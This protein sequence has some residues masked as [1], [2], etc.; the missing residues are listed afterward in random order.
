VQ[1]LCHESIC[2]AV[3]RA[4]AV[5]VSDAA[6]GLDDGVSPLEHALGDG[7]DFELVFAVSPADGAT[8]LRDQP[9]PGITLVAIGECVAEGMWLEAEGRQ[10]PLRPLGY[11]HALE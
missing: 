6:R 11:V 5:P 3:L 8:L 2:G 4:E 7:E 1:H 10:H 9:V